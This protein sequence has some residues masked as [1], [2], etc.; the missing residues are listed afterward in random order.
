MGERNLSSRDVNERTSLD[1]QSHL[2]LGA[3]VVSGVGFIAE[4]LPGWVGQV[5]SLRTFCAEGNEG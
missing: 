3:Y 5:A 4:D 1:A 2:N